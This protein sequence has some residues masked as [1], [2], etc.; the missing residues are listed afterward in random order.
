MNFLEKRDSCLAPRPPITYLGPAPQGTTSAASAGAVGDSPDTEARVHVA[1]MQQVAVV[2]A[3]TGR[4]FSGNER[5]G[6]RG[7]G[8]A[9]VVRDELSLME[10]EQDGCGGKSA[11]MAYF[12]ETVFTIKR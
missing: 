2:T 7:A 10:T 1:V 5:H 9:H 6:A 8:R 12:I 11:V 3:T 4:R